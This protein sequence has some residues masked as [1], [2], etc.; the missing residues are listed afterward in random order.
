MLRDVT[1]DQ[2]MAGTTATLTIDRDQAARFGM[3]PQVIDDT[4]YDAFGQRQI[5]Q[6]F[7]QVNSY[8]LILE[9]TP[10]CR[11]DVD[12]LNKLYVKS[13]HRA[14]GAAVDL[15]EVDDGAGAAAVDQPPEPVPGG[16]ASR[17]IWRPAPRSARRSTRSMPRCG[18]W[19]C[20]S[21]LQGT[22]QGTAQAFQSSLSTPALSDRGGTD[23]RLHHPRH[24]V[25]ELHPAADHPVH[26]ALGRRRRAA[27]ADD[28]CTTICR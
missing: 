26:A 21:P 15:R 8:H 17:S 22:F 4:L 20:R 3:Q 5:A 14:G 2:Q 18:R 16:D 24:P 19:A 11:D 1:T 12:T 25:R 13:Q 10:D 6:Y 9:V 28:R 23:H 7:S 27:D